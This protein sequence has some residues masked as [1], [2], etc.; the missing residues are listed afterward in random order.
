MSQCVPGCLRC[1]RVSQGV[2]GCPRVS[3]GSCSTTL[4][5]T[6]NCAQLSSRETA[7]GVALARAAHGADTGGVFGVPVA[8]GVQQELLQCSGVGAEEEGNVQSPDKNK[9]EEQWGC[10]RKDVQ[11]QTWPT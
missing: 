7:V 1:P 6:Q 5:N 4:A 3:Q 11:G 8:L 2:S 10:T 9:Q